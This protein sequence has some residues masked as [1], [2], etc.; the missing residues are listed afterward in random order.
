MNAIDILRNDTTPSIVC[1][2]LFGV[3]TWSLT[4]ELERT[5]DVIMLTYAQKRKCLN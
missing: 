1:I 5:F 3:D 2:C 4:K